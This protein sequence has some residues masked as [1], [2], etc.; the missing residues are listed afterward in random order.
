MIIWTCI[1]TS[2]LPDKIDGI[3]KEYALLKIR[4]NV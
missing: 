3:D 4:L 1:R 2:F